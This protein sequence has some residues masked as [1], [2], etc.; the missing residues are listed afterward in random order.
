MASPSVTQ[1]GTFTNTAASS[2]NYTSTAIT[3]ASDCLWIGLCVEKNTTTT[4]AVSGITSTGVTWSKVNEFAFTYAD[5][6]VIYTISLWKAPLG[7]TTTY[8][9]TTVAISFGGVSYDALAGVFFAVTGDAIAGS[10]TLDPNASLP[11]EA[12]A[13][14]GATPGV[15][16]STTNKDDLLVELQGYDSASSSVTPNTY[17]LI[18]NAAINGAANTCKMSMNYKSVSTTQSSQSLAW[19]AIVNSMSAMVVAQ[20]ADPPPPQHLFGSINAVIGL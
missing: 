7:S 13:N 9:A 5:T 4:M 6:S 16:Y 19:G 2:Y 15:T 3:S 10:G 20:T 17:T 18:A 8:G 12:G 1:S 14:S 11:A